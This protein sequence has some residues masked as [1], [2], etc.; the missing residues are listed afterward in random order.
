LHA[1][2]WVLEP[3][4]TTTFGETKLRFWTAVNNTGHFVNG[5][6]VVQR[7]V[8]LVSV[9][10]ESLL[11][12][13]VGQWVQYLA[14]HE[15]TVFHIWD[16]LLEDVVEFVTLDSTVHPKYDVLLPALITFVNFCSDAYRTTANIEFMLQRQATS[17]A[18]VPLKLTTMDANILLSTYFPGQYDV[19]NLQATDGLFLLRRAQSFV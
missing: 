13:T 19:D 18:S 11:V 10:V 5:V 1:A 9:T 2:Y 17:M 15:L 14:R 8:P 3:V 4:V 7:D 12:R 16:V 6:F